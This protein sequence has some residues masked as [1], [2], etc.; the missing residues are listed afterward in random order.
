MTFK[1][2]PKNK[3]NKNNWI[4]IIITKIQHFTFFMSLLEKC[5]IFSSPSYDSSF[6]TKKQPERGRY[7]EE[8]GCGGQGLSRLSI[9]LLTCL[10]CLPVPNNSI[11]TGSFFFSFHFFFF[12][13]NF[14]SVW[15]LGGRATDRQ[16]D[17]HRRRDRQNGHS[18]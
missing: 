5:W 16:T 6:V 17:R 18:Q 13:S 12:F 11:S 14:Y 8:G 2:I 9:C 3:Y 10:F 1:I 4:I 7:E 15:S